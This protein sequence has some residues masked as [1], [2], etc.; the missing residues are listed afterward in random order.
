MTS[1]GWSGITTVEEHCGSG[2]VAP[3]GPFVPGDVTDAVFGTLPP[4][5]T[6]SGG[7]GSAAWVTTAIVTVAPAA[8]V[9]TAH[10]IVTPSADVHVSDRRKLRPAG[11]TSVTVTPVAATGVELVTA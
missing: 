5:V 6:S 8:V 11:R 10:V 4:A 2:G 1:C 7:N 3:G 9:A